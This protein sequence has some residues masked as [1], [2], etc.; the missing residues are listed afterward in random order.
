[1][2]ISGE[3]IF[4]GSFAFAEGLLLLF[5]SNQP[6]LTCLILVLFVGYFAKSSKRH[7]RHDV[8]RV[9]ISENFSLLLPAL[10]FIIR[11]N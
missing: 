9:C 4:T 5:E 1:M 3:C 11:C 7:F 10:G 8:T 2:G 6:S